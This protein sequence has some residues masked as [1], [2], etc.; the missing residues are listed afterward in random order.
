MLLI[1]ANEGLL[2]AFAEATVILSIARSVKNS[3]DHNIEIPRL[4]QDSLIADGISF[5]ITCAGRMITSVSRMRLK[6]SFAL[7]WL[8]PTPTMAISE[9]P[10]V[11]HRGL[12]KPNWVPG[13]GRYKDVYIS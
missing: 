6:Q 7:V 3:L 4:T 1:G 12:R 5:L 2:R 10:Q 9:M 13:V 8:P 11:S